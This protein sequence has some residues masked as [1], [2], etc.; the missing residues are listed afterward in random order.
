M[1]MS[2]AVTYVPQTVSIA[3]VVWTPPIQAA[4][5]EKSF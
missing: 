4:A 2:I 1:K 3:A 5:I